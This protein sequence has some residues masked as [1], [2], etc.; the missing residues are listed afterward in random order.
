MAHHAGAGCTDSEPAA[1]MARS[2]M[3]L[4]IRVGGRTSVLCR[5]SSRLTSRKS[6]FKPPIA[7]RSVRKRRG[8]TAQS[9]SA[10]TS[11]G[12]TMWPRRGSTMNT[13]ARQPRSNE[14]AWRS[15]RRAHHPRQSQ[16][17][18]CSR[19]NLAPA[20]ARPGPSYFFLRAPVARAARAA[21]C[22]YLRKSLPSCGWNSAYSTVACR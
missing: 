11:V 12:R 6:P 16:R 15:R 9:A 5:A 7:N 8:R 13:R 10:T 14:R 21:P 3:S 17:R 1:A 20:G 19:E 4:A 2:G 18:R 22:K